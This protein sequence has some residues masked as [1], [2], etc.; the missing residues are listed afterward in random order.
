MNM[1]Q[2]SEKQTLLLLALLCGLSLFVFLGD[3]LFNTRGE[4]REAIVAYSMLEH[5]NWVLPVNNGDEIAFKPP[6]LHW[7]VAAFSSLA[8]GV[9]EYTSRLPSA[10]AVWVMILGGFVFYARRRNVEVA[11]LMGLLTLTCFEVH[12]AAYACRV[13]M[14]LSALVV[15]A[16]YALY[17]WTE[18][19]LKGIPWLAWALMA[20]AAL[21]KGPVGVILPCGVAGVYLLLRGYNFFSLL[22]RFALLA[23]AALLPLFAWYYA[24]YLEP[25]GGERFLQLIYEENVL[26]FTGDMSYASHINPWYYNVVTIVAGFAPYTLL[27]LLALPFCAG[28]LKRLF[29]WPSLRRAFQLRTYREMDDVRLYSLLSFLVIFVFYCIPASKRSVYLLPV[30]PFLAM[31]LAEFLLWLRSRHAVVLRVFSHIMAGAAVLLF[32]VFLA[33]RLGWVS[34]DIFSGKHAAENAAFLHALHTAPLGL[35]QWVA[36]LLPVAVALFHWARPSWPLSVP[37]GRQLPY[38]GVAIVFAVFLALDGFYQPC[39]LNTKSDK[40]LAEQID[41]LVPEGT[42]YSYRSEYVEANRMHPFTINFYLDD[43][44]IPI[45]KAPVLPESGYLIVSGKSIETFVEEYPQLATELIFQS[46]RRSCDDRK[47]VSFYR[48]SRKP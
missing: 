4:P 36:I 15:L 23:V 10:L 28:T 2:K 31:F 33:V 19:G 22:W 44:V 20:G 38:R 43:R 29:R 17:R 48:F 25:H 1:L 26:R 7:C 40:A 45:D 46:E 6:L 21:T 34:E 32:A 3:T 37:A 41:A 18:R 11:L 12:R 5:G 39:V 9:S 14:L 24:A 30:Y 16:L 13:D 27:V 8:G 47:P 42:L 35:L